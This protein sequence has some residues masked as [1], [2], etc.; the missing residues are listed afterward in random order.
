MSGDGPAAHPE[1]RIL[2]NPVGPNAEFYAW[3]ARGELRLQHCSDCGAWRH[4]PRHRCAA[5]GSLA[6][7]F[8]SVSGRGRIF[9]W[10]VTHQQLDPAFA[11]PYAVVVVE[12]EE[13]P[14]LVGNL[15]GLAPAD[16]ALDLPVTAELEPVSDA[17]ALV[18]FR[19]AP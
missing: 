6:A 17:V 7:T 3:A 19:S 12:L 9:S 10:T 13:G 4:P 2:P 14:R 18:H 1:L 16:L 15:L 11:V 5:C 8:E